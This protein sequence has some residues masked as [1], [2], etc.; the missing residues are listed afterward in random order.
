VAASMAMAPEY[1]LL[2]MV[3]K[4]VAVE[5]KQESN[6]R[7]SVEIGNKFVFKNISFIPF[8]CSS[9]GRREYI[10]SHF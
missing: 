2:E 4:A 3:A 1:G 8:A 5:I 10:D 6:R 7:M 9:E